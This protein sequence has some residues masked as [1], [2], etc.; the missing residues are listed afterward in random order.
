MVPSEGVEPPCL[1]ALGSKPSVSAD[2]TNWAL[3]YFSAISFLYSGARIKLA[4]SF[5]ESISIRTNQPSLF[6]SSF[7]EDGSSINAELTSITV[8]ET[9]A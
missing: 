5:S 2:S 6:G 1:A 7:K 4:S 9:G 8:P 3:N